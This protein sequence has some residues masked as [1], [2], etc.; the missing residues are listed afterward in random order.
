MS[1]VATTN[2]F[3]MDPNLL[4]SVIKSQAGTLSKAL[5][6]GVMNSLDAGASRVDIS[7]NEA[8]FVIADN[9]KGFESEHDIT[10]W[11]GR[12]GTPHVEGDSQFGAFR[13]GRGQLFSYAAT[14][15]KSNCFE[16]S[17]DI[18]HRGLS[19]ELRA[20][21]GTVPVKGCQVTG[22]LYKPLSAYAL[23][24][25][26]TEMRQ[27]VA[28]TSKPVY[29]NGELYGNNPERLKSWTH[30]DEFAYYRVTQDATDLLVY[31][32]GV[33]VESMGEWQT[34]MGGVIVSK[35]RLQ[36]N[37]ARNSVMAQ[38]CPQWLAIKKELDRVVV[39]KLGAAKRLSDGER[40]YLARRVTSANG[41]L[42]SILKTAK[43]LTDPTG[44][45]SS[46]DVLRNFKRFVYIAEP[47]ALACAVHGSN[48]TFVV[49]DNLLHRFAA[50]DMGHWLDEMSRIPGLLAW[51]YETIDVK[52]VAEMG[53]GGATLA[54]ASELPARAGAAFKTL[55]WLNTEVAIRLA[56]KGYASR[57]RNLLLGKHKHNSFVA[58][59]NGHDYITANRSF[60][61]RFDKG[62]DGIHEW[63]QT[64]VHEYM[65]DSDDSESHSHGEVFF[66]KFHDAMFGGTLKLA[67]LA[68][69]GLMEY[70]K[71]LKEAGCSC[72]NE[73]RRQLKP[74][75]QV[76]S[77]A[78]A[79]VILHVH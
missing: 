27:F 72:P 13:M 60:L 21:P 28:F 77:S 29:V 10:N 55:Q 48:Q 22:V 64:L 71:N 65:H 73:L 78:Q 47:D 5:L 20:L 11:F 34:G 2:A 59:T 16:M 79:P 63:A 43:V 23:R 49:T 76:A 24:D 70:L 41:D 39:R 51:N 6:E 15:W 69:Q 46:L 66:T 26:L 62:L 18:E 31:N 25:V 45:H 44:R 75:A 35:Q 58:W 7:L 14:V 17:V 67:T 4:V 52:R 38:T 61:K 42:L 32:Q 3:T 37:F 57:H 53:F 50:H 19:Y 36:V 74:T 8:S 68:Q 56:S 1:T 30:E 9:G 12:F 40:R 33:F 54:E